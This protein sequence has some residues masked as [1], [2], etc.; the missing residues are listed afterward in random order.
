MDCANLSQNGTKHSDNIH[1]KT[2][3][4]TELKTHQLNNPKFDFSFRKQKT[5]KALKQ[6]S[7]QFRKNK[8]VTDE[9]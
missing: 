3:L 6:K 4:T 1:F 8:E 5:T 2:P 7:D 9:K